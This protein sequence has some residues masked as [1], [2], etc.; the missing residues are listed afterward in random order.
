MSVIRLTQYEIDI[1][2]HFR[3]LPYDSTPFLRPPIFNLLELSV[4]HVY[5]SVFR[6]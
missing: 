2:R 3:T 6:R 4:D 1:T 5:E